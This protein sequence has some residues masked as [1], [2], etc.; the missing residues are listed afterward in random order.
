MAK[1]RE[2][3]KDIRDKIVELHKAGI[4]YRTIGKQLGE[5]A[6]TVGA[7]IRKWKKFKMTVNLPRSGAPCKISPRAASIIM[8][9]VRDQPRTARQ[10]LVNDL[11][12]AGTT[13]SKKNISNTLHRHGLQ[14]CSAR[15]VPLL[16]PVHVKV[17]LKFANDHLDDPEEEW[18]KVMWSDETKIELFG[19]NSTRRVW[20][21]KKD[22]YNPKNTIPTMKHG[23]ENIMLWECFSAKGTG[24][25][26][27]LPS[28]R[29]LKMGRGWVF[30][31]D[32]DPKHTAR[33][34]K[35]WLRKKHLKVLEWPSQSP[36][37][38]P[39][40]NLWRELKVR[41]AQRQPRNLKDLEKICTEEWAKIPAAVCAN[42]VKNYRKR[43]IC[44]IANKGFCTKY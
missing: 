15:K 41:V 28:V 17:R 10:D 16:K 30:Q 34:T 12:R 8:R 23:G 26:N 21:K 20:R 29:A 13:V 44:V 40:E 31:H 25:N 3:C 2:L 43:L 33:A 37:L 22:E 42:L 32:N 27:L 38:N 35:E 11:K 5:K 24:S 18:E 19:L 39:I 1:T 9:K 4:G 7:I 14:S 36:D 6:T